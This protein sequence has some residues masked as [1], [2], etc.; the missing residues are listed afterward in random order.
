MRLYAIQIDIYE[1]ATKFA[2]PVVSH[3]MYGRTQ[4]EARGYVA[5]H[6]KSDK[7]LDACL[8]SGPAGTLNRFGQVE[9]RATVR[10][11]WVDR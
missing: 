11:G 9:C 4:A 10:E 7:F 6:R 8:G 1:A 2:Y 3:T 5:S